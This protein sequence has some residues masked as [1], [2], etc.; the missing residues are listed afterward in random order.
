MKRFFVLSGC[1][2]GGKSTLLDALAAT[3]I[4]T[5][6][7]PGRRI[8]AAA[9]AGDGAGLPWQDPAGF[10]TRALALARDDWHRAQALPGPVVF[11][12]GLIDAACAHEHATGHLPPAA[13]TLASRYNPLVFVAPPWPAIYA[14]DAGRR[15]DYSAALAEYHRLIAFFPRFG[16]RVIDVPRRPVAGRVAFVRATLARA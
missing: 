6:P 3:G 1:S 11:D 15:H 7:E 16:Y 5:I 8:V 12:R 4:A 9:L 10:A 2:G 14:A 13:A